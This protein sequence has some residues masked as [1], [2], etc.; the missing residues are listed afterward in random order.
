MNFQFLI[1]K[2]TAS[3]EFQKF[4]KENSDAYPFGGFF[5]FD[6]ENKKTQN[7]YSID[8]FIPSLSKAVSFKLEKGVE[9]LPITIQ[10]SQKFTEIGANYS[11]DFEEFQELIEKE[12]EKKEIKNKIQKILYSLQNYEKEDYLLAT[13]FLSGFGILQANV[14]IQNKEITKFE[15]RGFLDFLKIVKK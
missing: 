12:M 4:K 11:F 8:Y 7:Q 15:K 2:L 5:S 13:V 10:E 1:E 3:E 9:M 6:L 14:K